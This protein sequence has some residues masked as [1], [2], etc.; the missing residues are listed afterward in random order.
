MDMRIR[1]RVLIP[2]VLFLAVA[3]PAVVI[4]TATGHD[5]GPASSQIGANQTDPLKYETNWTPGDFD[6]QVTSDDVN[7]CLECYLGE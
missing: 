6:G 3:L 7:Q 4:P 5:A 1:A 2:A